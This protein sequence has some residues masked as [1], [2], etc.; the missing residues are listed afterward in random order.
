MLFQSEESNNN[1]IRGLGAP[2]VVWS[3]C[4]FSCSGACLF[5]QGGELSRC[6]GHRPLQ[7]EMRRSG[8]LKHQPVSWG[9][10]HTKEPLRNKHHSFRKNGELF[11]EWR[12]LCLS[13]PVLM[14]W[15][16]ICASARG[17]KPVASVYRDCYMQDW[18]IDWV[19]VGVLK[20][21]SWNPRLSFQ[22]CNVVPRWWWLS[23]EWLC[24]TVMILATAQMFVLF[25]AFA[26]SQAA[27]TQ[28][29][30]AN[31]DFH[32]WSMCWKYLVGFQKCPHL[33]SQKIIKET[34]SHW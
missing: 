3:P 6:R 18:N 30:A 10:G 28:A 1:F 31:D 27:V 24:I 34:S 8:R 25:T 14:V 15:V 13:A 33:K 2:T 17:A 26:A 22:V 23:C 4:L 21:K 12:R 5:V 19:Y 9:V 32:Y 29:A 11:L 7:G 16:T 20:H